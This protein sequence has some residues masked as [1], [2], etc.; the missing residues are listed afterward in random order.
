MVQSAEQRLDAAE[1]GNEC[2]DLFTGVVEGE[3]GTDSAL[4]AESLHQGLGAMMACAD[5]NAEFVKQHP[6]I[7]MVCVTHQEGDDGGF[8]VGRAKILTPGIS[9]ILAVA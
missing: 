7:V 2:V 4:D 1:G 6:G 9:I 5:G 8:S 3:R